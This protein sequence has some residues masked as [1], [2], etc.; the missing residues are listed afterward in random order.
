[1]DYN[2]EKRA[3]WDYIDED[4]KQLL[5]ESA[6]LVN[7]ASTWQ[8]KFHDY[9]FVVF[10]ACRNLLFHWFP[11]ERNVVNREEAEERVK[12][13]LSAMDAAFRDCKIND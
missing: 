7:K 2:L 9:S 5:R 12:Q 11:N 1:M 4:L 8:Q 3:W 10:P 6:L 13:I